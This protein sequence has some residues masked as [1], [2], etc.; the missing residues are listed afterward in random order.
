MKLF[1]FYCYIFISTAF[2]FSIKNKWFSCKWKSFC[3]FMNFIAE[4]FSFAFQRTDRNNQFVM[5]KGILAVNFINSKRF[6]TNTT[7][8]IHDLILSQKGNEINA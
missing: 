8:Y 4:K 7:F 1:N 3:N 5:P 6:F 2:A